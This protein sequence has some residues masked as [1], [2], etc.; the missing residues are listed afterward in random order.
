MTRHRVGLKLM[1]AFFVLLSL[2][3]SMEAIPSLLGSQDDP[4][5]LELLQVAVATTALSSF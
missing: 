3:A 4:L 2:S 1:A 5:V